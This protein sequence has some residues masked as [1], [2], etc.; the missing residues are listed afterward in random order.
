MASIRNSKNIWFWT[1][2]VLYT[3]MLCSWENSSSQLLCVPCECKQD[4]S[5]FQNI[6][7]SGIFRDFF[8]FLQNLEIRFSPFA[9]NYS[10]FSLIEGDSHKEKKRKDCFHAKAW[11]L[12]PQVWGLEERWSPKGCC[13]HAEPREGFPERVGCPSTWE[14]DIFK[15]NKSEA[16]PGL[17]WKVSSHLNTAWP[18]YEAG[19]VPESV[20]SILILSVYL[21]LTHTYPPPGTPFKR[22]PSLSKWWQWIWTCRSLKRVEICT[23]THLQLSYH[24]LV[25]V[26]Y[27]LQ[28]PR[29]SHRKQQ[30]HTVCPWCG[31]SPWHR[32]FPRGGQRL[33]ALALWSS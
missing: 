12:G 8:I 28:W 30:G 9:T 5:P 33:P 3:Q 4:L 29:L 22:H 1:S 10:S 31:E 20:F 14:K 16:Q 32:L 2:G 6:I 18:R 27:E 19:F 25:Q 24:G 26:E 11:V 23:Q 15:L 21:C 13:G 7:D 17:V